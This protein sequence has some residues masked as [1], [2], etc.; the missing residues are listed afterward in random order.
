MI[1]Q[2]EMNVTRSKMIFVVV[3]LRIRLGLK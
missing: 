1:G 3:I 2:N